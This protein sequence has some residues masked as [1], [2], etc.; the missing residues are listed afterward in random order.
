M[1]EKINE[2]FKQKKKVEK[3]EDEEEEIKE[4]DE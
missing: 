3:G 4:T 2:I 1:L